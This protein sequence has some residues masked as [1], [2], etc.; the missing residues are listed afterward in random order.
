M[1]DIFL[2]VDSNAEVKQK[3]RTNKITISTPYNGSKVMSFRNEKI[4]LVDGN[5]TGRDRAPNTTR[6]FDE[7]VAET[8]TITDPVTNEE[9]T[10]SVAG[11]A[12]A[13][14]EAYVK[15]WNEDNPE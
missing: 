2:P 10:I 8:I 6:N 4:T 1:T 3:V 11:V 12:T 5:E 13:I 14:E 15:W 9:I 7:V